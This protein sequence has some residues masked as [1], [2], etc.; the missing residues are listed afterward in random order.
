MLW[1]SLHHEVLDR[2]APSECSQFQA[3]WLQVIIEECWRPGV[4]QTGISPEEGQGCE[5]PHQTQEG[6]DTMVG[7]KKKPHFWEPRDRI[8]NYKSI[9]GNPIPGGILITCTHSLQHSVDVVNAPSVSLK[10]TNKTNVWPQR[11][12]ESWLPEPVLRSLI[13]SVSAVW[14]GKKMP[15]HHYQF[16]QQ[17]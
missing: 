2:Q 15:Q 14:S 11:V 10:E 8:L 9:T 17:F 6:R 1:G 13:P 5:V 16:K 4:N 3:A 12:P 7:I